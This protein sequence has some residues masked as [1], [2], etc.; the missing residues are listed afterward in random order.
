MPARR[1]AALPTLLL[2]ALLLLPSALAF[3]AR[4]EPLTLSYARADTPVVFAA[5]ELGV[6]GAV[7][8]GFLAADVRGVT[9]RDV[10][11]VVVAEKL[12]AG[13]PKQDAYRNV[14]LVVHSGS[15]LLRQEGGARLD[16]ELGAPY[17][18]GMA[19]PRLPVGGEMGEGGAVLLAAPALAGSF[20]F[21]GVGQ[22]VPLDAEVSMLD[23]SG[24]PL[25]G[26][27]RRDVNPGARLDADPTS[28]SHAFRVS[29]P[30]RGESDA[31]VQGAVIGTGAPF[32]L[33][34]SSS[35][36]DRYADTLDALASAA[37][38][39]GPDAAETLG[40]ENPM[41]RLEPF[42][43]VLNGALV[44]LGGAPGEAAPEPLVAR[45]GEEDFDV[46]PLALMRG[47]D[48]TLA[49]EDDAMSVRGTPKVTI[50]GEGF[51]VEEPATVGGLVP[52]L[53]LVL[54]V[55]ALAAVVVFFVKRP[56]KG[57]GKLALRLFS[58]GVHVAVFALVF[59]WWDASFAE[60]F[61]T[62]VLTLLFSGGAFGDLPRLGIVAALEMAP[63]GLAALLFALP[64]RIVAGVALRYL[65]KGKSY[66]GVASAAGLAALGILGPFYALWLLNTV[67]SKALGSMPSMFG[68]A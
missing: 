45:L 28:F 6:A 7:H 9:L 5:G 39:L 18:L 49:W 62:S 66:K 15:L 30:F 63:W 46:G 48:M 38:A 19:L 40:E 35:A 53:A 3:A 33:S 12:A 55:C 24:A 58:L 4:E 41:Y 11:L 25:S 2:A 20:A 52:V 27:D 61:G 16:L 37:V 56:P 57:E 43:A 65:G 14:T 29:G 54:W 60:T 1:A 47:E 13:V 68:G 21:R 17:G 23:A 36:Q 34:V 67:V 50:A 42:S 22:F 26:W 8:G 59:L 31:R 10:P 32:S 51:A 64:V 44:V